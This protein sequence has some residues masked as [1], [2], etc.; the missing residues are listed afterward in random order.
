MEVRVQK[1]PPNVVAILARMSKRALCSADE[2]AELSVRLASEDAQ[3][4][5]TAR[6]AD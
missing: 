6:S 3:T 5:L 1:V 4:D 2:D